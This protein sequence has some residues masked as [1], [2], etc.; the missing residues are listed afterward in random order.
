MHGMFYETHAHTK[1]CRHAVGDPSDYVEQARRIGLDGMYFTCHN[2]LPDGHSAWARMNPEVFPDYVASVLATRDQFLGAMDIRLGLEC[3]YVAEFGTYLAR[4]IASAPFHYILGSLHPQFKEY[5]DAYP[6]QNPLDR[7]RTY[8]ALLAE[9]AETGLFDSISHPDLIKNET[10]DGWDP[11][12]LMDDIRR[13][14]DRIAATG[15]AM[16]VNTSGLQKRVPEMNPFP[17]MLR[18]MAL[19]GIPVTLGADAHVAARVGANFPAALRMIAAAG[20]EHVSYFTD[21]K[22]EEAPVSA[23]LER[24]SG[25][26]ELKGESDLL[27]RS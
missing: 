15:V 17:G 21:R 1:F 18:E 6:D 27:V 13:A 7:Q 2:P 10:S 25:R 14:L 23:F 12:L 9:S 5:Q 19:R 24:L 3:D 22:R 11:A 8:F 16:E 20:Y 4:Q 26:A